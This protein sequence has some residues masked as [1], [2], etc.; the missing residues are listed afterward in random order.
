M[1]LSLDLIQFMVV[2]TIDACQKELIEKSKPSCWYLFLE[3]QYP[4]S[5]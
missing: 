5:K 4:P 1:A 2:K 3:F